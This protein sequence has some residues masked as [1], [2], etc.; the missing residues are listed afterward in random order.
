[1]RL[2]ISV[3]MN[4]VSERGEE[5]DGGNDDE[6]RYRRSLLSGDVPPTVN[7]VGQSHVASGCLPPPS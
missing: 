4:E 6:D 7:G 3:E 5:K 1:M 2:W